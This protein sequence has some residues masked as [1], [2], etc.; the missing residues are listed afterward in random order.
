M[1]DVLACRQS[2][3]GRRR[4]DG[5]QGGAAWSSQAG[6]HGWEPRMGAACWR[7]EARRGWQGQA[8]AVHAQHI[9]SWQGRAL[10]ATSH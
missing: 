10:L 5:S 3:K 9:A 8:G 6:R 1:A 2:G 7:F 4:A